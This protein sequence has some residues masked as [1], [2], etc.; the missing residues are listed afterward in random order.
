M[1]NFLIPKIRHTTIFIAT[2]GL[3][4][5]ASS[6]IAGDEPY[7]G[8]IIMTAATYCPRGFAVAD[9]Q[10]LSI[11]SNESL[12]SLYGT[13]Y[14]GDGRVS[15]GLPDLR[16]RVPLA[17]GSGPGLSPKMLGQKGGTYSLNIQ[18]NNLAGHS[19]IA[20]TTSQLKALSTIG[21]SST[22][23]GNLLADDDGDN[24]YITNVTPNITMSEQAAISVTTVAASAGS[25]NEV[26]NTQQPYTTI[27]YCVALFGIY[28]SR[29]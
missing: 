5:N 22:P 19:H 4:F 16:N 26:I 21:T 29:S 15:F 20:T 17:A 6:S 28:P 1:S 12:Y 9:G 14:G 13:M 10:I 27:R 11:A 7:V 24:V 8:D 3:L 25:N 2:L 18:A 23:A